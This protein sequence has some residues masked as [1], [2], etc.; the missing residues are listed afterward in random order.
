MLK[1]GVI[2]YGTRIKSIVSQLVN[3][4]EVELKAVMDIDIESVKT[5]YI[6]PNGYENVNFYSDA[7]EMLKNEKLDGVCIGTRCSLHT[8][9]ALLV[10]KYNIPMFLEKPVSISYDELNKLKEITHMDKKTVVS[11]P[12]R[13]SNLC[14]YVKNIIDSGRLGE[15]THV[16][17]YNNVPYGRG[18]YHLWYRDDS[19]TGGL[20]LQK[21]THDLDY[22]NYLLGDIKPV[23]V[24]AMESK[25]IYKGNKPAGLKCADCDERETC[26]ESD[27]NVAKLNNGFRIGEYC[28]FAVDTG[29]QDS[30]SI[31]VKY[32][33][34]LHVVYTQNFIARNKAGK[35]GAR[36]IGYD[37]TLEFDWSTAT[38][39]VHNHFENSSDT[40]VFGTTDGHGG[41]DELLCNDF[42]GVMKGEKESSSPLSDGILSAEMCLAARKSATENVFVDI[43]SD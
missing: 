43:T 25:Q 38:V 7:E 22:I 14:V 20:F 24:C 26:R 16:Q 31:I 41:G 11:F 13:L 19:E 3:T 9:Y 8:H 36:F 10:A 15:I 18:Y 21:S 35:R 23:K 27:I 1:L 40:K 29:N 30:G 5:K 17:A 42:L 6:C 4:G 12:L 32:D 34:G 39:T 33:N 2:G 37:A 28:C